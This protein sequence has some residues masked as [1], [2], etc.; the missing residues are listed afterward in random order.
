MAREALELTPKCKPDVL[1]DVRMPKVNGID[2]LRLQ[3]GQVFPPVTL[4]M[5]LDYDE[6]LLEGI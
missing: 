5:T 4:L 2:L 6:A 3:E 1:L